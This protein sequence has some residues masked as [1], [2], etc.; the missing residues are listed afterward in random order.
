MQ[1]SC[2]ACTLHA[3]ILP[4]QEYLRLLRADL[5][6]DHDAALHECAVQ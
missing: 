5:L 3:D 1:A 6:H 4:A 2:L